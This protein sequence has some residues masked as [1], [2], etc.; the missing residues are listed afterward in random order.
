MLQKTRMPEIQ[1]VEGECRLLL[2]R[3]SRLL[4]ILDNEGDSVSSAFPKGKKH[5]KLS[6]FLEFTFSDF[7]ERELIT[8]KSLLLL[9][10][11]ITWHVFYATLGFILSRTSQP[12]SFNPCLKA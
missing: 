7:Q 2:R 3:S 4:R 9:F 6:A 10:L 11:V 8:P 1:G 5:D 12:P